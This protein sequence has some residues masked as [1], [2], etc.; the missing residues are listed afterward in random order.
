MDLDFRNWRDSL[1]VVVVDGETLR[2][3]HGDRLVS[4]E[5][6]FMEWVSLH[7]PELLDQDPEGSSE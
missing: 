4:D 6:A 1:P 5:E 2:V 7:C 3:I